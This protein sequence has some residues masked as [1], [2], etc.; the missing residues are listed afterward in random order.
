MAHTGPFRLYAQTAFFGPGLQLAQFFYAERRLCA[1]IYTHLEV[2]VFMTKQKQ[3]KCP[4]CHAN[5]S[6][7]PASTVYGCG[8][9][10]QG[11][12]IY[13]CDRWPACDAYVSAHSRTHRP[14]G[15]LANGDLRHKRILA[16]RAL[17]HL[18]K[19]RHMEKWEVYI[20]LQ[21]KLGLNDR[22][23]HIPMATAIVSPAKTARN[24][25]QLCELFFRWANLLHR[26]NNL[27]SR[28]KASI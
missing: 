17:E 6:L 16:H 11:K 10:S 27:W 4:Y 24:W 13:L 15:T 26:L 5:A 23:A 22:Q 9:R 19:I 2:M 20:W 12:Y 3:I 18:Q 14:M 21:S 28:R 1:V 7:R 25:L 8:R